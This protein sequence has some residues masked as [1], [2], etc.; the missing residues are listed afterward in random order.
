MKKVLVKDRENLM[1]LIIKTIK[2]KG[3]NADLN[4]IDTSAV[5]DMTGLFSHTKFNGNISEWDT[6][7]VIN[8]SYMFNDSLF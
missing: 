4:F 7:K 5:T 8:M 3:P 1:T 2:E 6:A